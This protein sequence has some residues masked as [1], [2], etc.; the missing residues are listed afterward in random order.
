MLTTWYVIPNKGFN[1][2]LF[3]LEFHTNYVVCNFF[4]NYSYNIF[5]CF[6]FILTTWCV[7][8]R[9]LIE[10][11]KVIDRFMLTTWYVIKCLKTNLEAIFYSFMLTTWYVIINTHIITIN[12]Y[13]QF[14]A[15]YVV[16][17]YVTNLC[18]TYIK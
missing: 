6:S 15:N 1:I 18:V 7:I 17:K 4:I 5:F 8:G 11:Y 10:Q 9:E 3:I 12:K 13:I 2:S 14:Y 16:C